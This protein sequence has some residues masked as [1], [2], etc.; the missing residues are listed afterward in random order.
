MEAI[1]SA[2]QVGAQVMSLD[3]QSGLVKDGYL[4]DL[5]LVDGDPLADIAIL[6][7]RNRIASV[8]KDG[9]FHRTPEPAVRARM[10]LAS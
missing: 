5:I 10:A 1:Q 8:M 2:T 7:D 6:Q 3:G 4:A 9:V